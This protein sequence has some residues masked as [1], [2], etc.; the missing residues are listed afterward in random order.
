VVFTPR[1]LARRVQ[2]A[3]RILSDDGAPDERW[4]PDL[5]RLQVL[6]LYRH[7]VLER[8]LDNR[9]LSLQRQGR[10]GFYGPAVG[11]EATIVGGAFA[12]MPQDWIFP[13]YRETGA[14]LLRG[15]PLRTLI[16]QF[17]GNADD[18]S[19]GR[20]MPCHYTWKDGRF[21][22]ISSV[23][24][25]RITQAVGAAWAAKIRGDDTAALV[26][27]G[28][29]ASSTGEFHQGMNFAGV[30][31]APVVFLCNNNQY[32]ISVPF[33]K[34]TAAKTVAGRA[35]AYG[36]EGTRVDGMDALAVYRAVHDACLKAHEGGGPTLVEALTYRLGP[37]SSS[38]DPARYRPE[39]ELESWQR[40]DPVDLFRKYLIHK[41]LWSEDEDAHLAE[42]VEAEI[43]VAIKEAE[44]VS[45]P[46]TETLF[47]DVY[48][49]PPGALA[50]QREDTL[51]AHREV[52]GG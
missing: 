32:A 42:A 29:G 17:L 11:Q 47:E 21:V 27:F 2:E 43:S 3:F 15:L 1:P 40:R 7:M 39:G 8:H 22:S 24:G 34:Q 41:A 44:A 13:Q 28:D 38:D 20:Q 6:G 35:K 16:C 19:K 52:R 31:V 48:A 25:P 14:A 50:E 33:S 49:H 18:L 26:Y 12:M 30:F 36:F 23:V 45:L 9:M 10:I 51:K 46:R 37:H 4:E 5:S